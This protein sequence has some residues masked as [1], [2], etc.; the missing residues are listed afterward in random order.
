MMTL[1]VDCFVFCH[2]FFGDLGMARIPVG[3]KTVAKVGKKNEFGLKVEGKIRVKE[4]RM[5]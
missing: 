1:F 2:I 5:S 3:V 4:K